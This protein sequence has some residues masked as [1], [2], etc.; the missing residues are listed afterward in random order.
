M[1]AHARSVAR[2]RERGHSLQQ[3]KQA[4]KEGRLA[5]SLVEDLLPP[6]AGEID[7]KTAAKMTGLERAL[8]ERIWANIGMPTSS[9]D[10][11]SQ[12]DI[13]A[14]KYLAAVLAAGF[15]L[16]AL[17]QLVRVYGQCLR[18]IADAEAHLVHIYVHEPLMQEGVG[19]MEMAEE[20]EGLVK[21]ILPFASPLMD[22]VHKRFLRYYVEQDV[23]GHMENDP[24][25]EELG[26]LKVVIGFADLAGFTRFT[27]EAGEE[28][29]L[30][31]VEK[32]TRKVE[33]SLPDEARVVKTIGD[34][35]MIVSSDP[36]SL[37]NWAVDFQSMFKERP[38]PRIG[39]HYGATIYRDGDFYGS[40][41]NLAARVTARAQG[42]E[43]LV[44]RSLVE[45]CPDCPE[46]N[47]EPIGKVSLKGFKEPI[48]LF[49]ASLNGKS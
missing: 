37:S 27:E 6:T 4:V 21:D 48:T 26:R 43:V 49:T 11:F 16:V 23:V 5:T 24:D 35:V 38:R 10:S 15:P 25:S 41:V 12:E 17:L 3:I 42:G 30:D 9:H 7:I 47:F 20:M 2:M 28:E 39:L 29:A 36:V 13:V 14:L 40:E 44:T 22:F 32:F 31:L 46:I 45:N 33:E 34:E 1:A 8:I 19:G 18:Q